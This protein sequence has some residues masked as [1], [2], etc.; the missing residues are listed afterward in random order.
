MEYVLIGNIDVRA[1][2]AM[3]N[4]L[5]VNAAP[6]MPAVMFAHSLGLE[7]KLGVMP[8]GVALIHHDAQFCSELGE[9]GV[10]CFQQRRGA[11][12]IDD[13]DYAKGSNSLSLQPV[14]NVHLMVSL[15]LRFPR[16]VNIGRLGEILS[17]LRLSGGT[18][19]SYSGID[20][21][22]DVGEIL[23]KVSGGFWVVD[24]SDL[25]PAGVDPVVSLINAVGYKAESCE[26]SDDDDP[27]GLD[28]ENEVE[29]NSWVVPTTVGYALISDIENRGGVRGGYMHAFAEP[30]IG[31]VQYRSVRGWGGAIPFWWHEWCGKDVFLVKQCLV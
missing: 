12:L 31:L 23:A 25:M 17:E 24:R 22:S 29:V 8:N 7:R 14:A 28:G 20:S 19:V 2:N 16:P 27:M 18:A 26:R 13:A 11:A 1:A 6:V 5:L 9:Y 15:L 30:M 3:S 4:Q 10:V 21:A